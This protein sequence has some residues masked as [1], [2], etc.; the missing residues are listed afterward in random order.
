MKPNLRLPKRPLLLLLLGP[1]HLQKLY[2][3]RSHNRHSHRTIYCRTMATSRALTINT[4]ATPKYTQPTPRDPTQQHGP[5]YLRF[6]PPAHHANG[7]GRDNV[8]SSSA[9]DW[10][11]S[12][13]QT[14]GAASGAVTVREA[15]EPA[16]DNIPTDS[17][18]GNGFAIPGNEDSIQS[19]VLSFL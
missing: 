4:A 3:Q 15:H 9:F 11:T 12:F 13:D 19:L 1:T 8:A 5:E 2:S 17:S 16:I 10:A 18:F 6:A 7:N 14:R